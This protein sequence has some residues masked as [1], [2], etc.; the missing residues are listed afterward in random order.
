MLELDF[1][2]L[3]HPGS[4][5][6]NNEDFAGR[7]IPATQENARSHGW[8]FAV[9]DGVGGQAL[10]EV[11]SRTAVESILQDF[12]KAAPG[13]SHPAVLSRIVK[14]ANT[15]VYETGKAASPGGVPMA[16]TLVACALRFDK[17]TVAHVGDS[18]CYLIR[19]GKAT[20]LTRDHTVVSDQVRL[21]V[22]SER[23]AA[24]AETRHILSRSLG[25]NLF[26][27]VDVEE[28]QVIPDDVLLLCSDGLYGPVPA[29]DLAHIVGDTSDLATAAERLLGLANSRDGGDNVTMQLIQVRSVERVGMYRGRPYKL[30]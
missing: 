21:G 14:A 6:T 7:V 16:T 2:E 20:A 5:R 27:N 15:L 25:G 17:A 1:T 10:G 11:A 4:V 9:A 8:L 22:M 12:R 13:E 24:V 3:T 28:H 19:A 30:R 18:R 26:V 23:E 29:A